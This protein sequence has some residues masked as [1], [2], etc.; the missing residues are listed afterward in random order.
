MSASPVAVGGA[1]VHG[2]PAAGGV[3]PLPGAGAPEGVA[4][5]PG[6]FVLPLGVTRMATAM[7]RPVV[8]PSAMPA[9]TVISASCQRRRAVVY[10]APGLP[11]P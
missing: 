2:L 8:T 5:A 4:I 1:D 11:P 6:G 10:P 9:T 7:T 3:A